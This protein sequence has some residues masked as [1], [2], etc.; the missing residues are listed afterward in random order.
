[1]SA[2]QNY[3]GMEHGVGLVTTL[4]DATSRSY[5][6]AYAALDG[7]ITSAQLTQPR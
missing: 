2:D 6:G 7:S 4:T 3:T 1:V 5:T